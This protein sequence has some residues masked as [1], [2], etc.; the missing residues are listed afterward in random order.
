V[1]ASVVG[2]GAGRAHQEGRG[3]VRFH[4]FTFAP[5]HLVIQRVNPWNLAI[6][7]PMQQT[8]LRLLSRINAPGVVPPNLIAHCKTY[9]EAVQLCWQLR[10]RDITRVQLA[11]EA[12]LYAPHVTSYLNDSA[13]LPRDLPGYA[14]RGFETACGNAAI[15]QWHASNAKLTLLEEMQAMK[16]LLA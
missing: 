10:V 7:A 6:E 11:E 14:V 5:V 2:G 13:R 9:R 1:G 4:A 8:E 3:F 15:S 12:G 16:A